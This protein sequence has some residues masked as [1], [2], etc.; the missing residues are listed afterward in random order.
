MRKKFRVGTIPK[1]IKAFQKTKGGTQKLKNDPVSKMLRDPKMVVKTPTK[2]M[3]EAKMAFKKLIDK[4]K[5]KPLDDEAVKKGYKI[6][7]KK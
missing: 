1:I 6:F 7:T 4:Y 2:E 3:K 5:N